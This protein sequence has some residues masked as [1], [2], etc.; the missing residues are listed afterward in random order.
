M[1]NYKRIRNQ[2]SSWEHKNYKSKLFV[3]E[4]K[5]TG[6]KEGTLKANGKTKCW[7]WKE[8]GKTTK[9]KRNI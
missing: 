4:T 7:T 3:R 2:I 9:V 6:R 1:S 8:K 5:K